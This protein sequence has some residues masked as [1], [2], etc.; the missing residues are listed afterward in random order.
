VNDLS[1]L[2]LLPEDR[3]RR[4]FTAAGKPGADTS[5]QL[6]VSQLDDLC[7]RA[8][9][10]ASAGERKLLGITGPPGAGKST[11][12]RLVVEKAGR[13]SRLVEMD[14]FHLSQSRLAA[15]GCLERKG[16]LDTFDGAG[17][18]ELVLRLRCQDTETV[19]APEFR[20]DLEEPVAGSLAVEPDVQLIV[21]EGNYLLVPQGPWGKL[22]VL[23]D[24]VWYCEP[25]EDV[26]LQR[27][28]ARHERY[29]KSGE[30]ARR[31]TFG[32]D[33][34]NAGLIAATRGRADVIVGLMSIPGAP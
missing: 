18:L 33:Q 25:G 28:V 11:L 23:F 26:R 9:R 4:A 16:A 27:L 29:G 5:A 19:Y 15:L 2:V 22:R 32:P 13:R 31:W 12:A 1:P 30:E 10:L 14:G 20:R 21:V 3:V 34:R 17:F 6:H 8:A 7:A 24:E